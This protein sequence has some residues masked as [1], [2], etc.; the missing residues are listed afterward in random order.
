MKPHDLVRT[1]QRRRRRRR[2]GRGEGSG[3]GKTSGRGMLGQGARSGPGPTPGFEGGQTPLLRRFPARRG[4]TND[5]FRTD[6]QPVNLDRLAQFDEGSV[7]GAAE[8]RARGIIDD[9]LFK[10][11]AG[12]DLPHPLTIRAPKFSAAAKKKIE[13]AG[14]TAEETPA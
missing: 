9:G 3:R 13:E 4:F 5:R 8:L 14:G 10:I 1:S 7:V 6:Y 11:L 12:G 2:V